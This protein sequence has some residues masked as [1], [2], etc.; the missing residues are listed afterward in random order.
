MC[1]YVKGVEVSLSPRRNALSSLDS[2]IPPVQ[3][4]RLAPPDPPIGSATFAFC[5]EDADHENCS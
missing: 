2:S 1:L 4:G 5:V 3:Q